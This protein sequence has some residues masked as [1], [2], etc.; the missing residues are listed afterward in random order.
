MNVTIDNHDVFYSTG[1]RDPDPAQPNIIFIHGTALDNTTWTLF[2][3]YYA[4]RGYNAYAMDL[5]GHGHS[6]GEPLPSI[7][8]MADWI[9][10][11]MGAVGISSA[12]LVGHSMGGLV[13]IETAIRH[14]EKVD[15]LALLGVA[16]PMPVAPVFLEAARNN[17]QLATDM[18]LLFGFDYRA[19]LGGNPLSGI[20][21]LNSGMRLV[22]R[23]ADGVMY[24]G[25]N[26]CNDYTPDVEHLQKVS[27]PASL[28][29]GHGDAMTPY[30]RALQL[31]GNLN[32]AHV[33]GIPE[34]GHMLM[35]ERPEEVHLAL[36]DAVGS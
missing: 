35:A 31:A 34:C 5:P 17:E 24:C 15:K 16:L 29:I 7:E 21:M 22:E 19:Q 28:I 3:R 8:A 27:C 6:A 12:T 20:N 11:F 26:A 13:A 18:F 32:S 9:A 36:L 25:L 1:K 14:P 4:R 10:K 23:C 33:L 2:T 30:K